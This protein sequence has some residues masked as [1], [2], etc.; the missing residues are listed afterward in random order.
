MGKVS[1]S[2]SARSLERELNLS[3]DP[4]EYLNGCKDEADTLYKD[5]VQ[6]FGESGSSFTMEGCLLNDTIRQLMVE[7]YAKGAAEENVHFNA[8][9]LMYLKKGEPT[10]M[11]IY[12]K[13]KLSKG[14]GA[15]INFNNSDL[16]GRWIAEATNPTNDVEKEAIIM[17]SK[18]LIH[19]NLRDSGRWSKFTE[20][21]S[22]EIA[23]QKSNSMAFY[24]NRAADLRGLID[25]KEGAAKHSEA[26]A[27]LLTA[28]TE[29]D[30][31][32]ATLEGCI[33]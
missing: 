21:Y 8:D 27:A 20:Q 16:F 24:Q 12:A 32:L 31:A 11:D 22:R 4:I 29:A 25:S 13:Y 9:C 6:L 15:D 23:A 28:W 18:V 30:S 2:K 5:F 17:T 19:R 10:F 14:P 1:S 3:S 7:H 33:G 26:D